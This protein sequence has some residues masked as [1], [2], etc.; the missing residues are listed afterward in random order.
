MSIAKIIRDR[1]LELGLSDVE[2]AEKLGLTPSGLGDLELHNDELETAVSLGT[3]RCLCSLLGLSLWQVLEMPVGEVT[4]LS[5][6]QWPGELVRLWREQS[7]Y[8]QLDLA[9]RVGFDEATIKWLET[10]PSFGNTLPIFLLK[11]IEAELKLPEGSLVLANW[12][13]PAR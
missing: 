7:G 9:E 12:D 1:R 13:Q 11:D 10:I 6:E 2:V 3:V 8:S 5:K 4:H